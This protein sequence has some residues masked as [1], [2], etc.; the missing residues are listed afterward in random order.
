MV[1]NYSKGIRE[2]GG[3]YTH[4][5]IWAVI[6][7]TML[8]LNEKA[9]EYFKIINPIEHSKTKETSNKYKVEPYVVAADIYGNGDLAGRGGWTWYTGSSSW[10]YI[11]IIEYILGV[12]IKDNCLTI[13]PHIP[14]FWEEYEVKLN[15]KTSLYN[16]KISNLRRNGQKKIYINNNLLNE[17]M[18]RL[19]DD[20]KIYNIEVEI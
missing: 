5:A 14:D 3:Q 2:N 18:I 1:M 16:I 7:N 8:G 19:Y 15:Y 6:A 10:M 11:A 20:G 13:D 12:R 9:Y 17:D 4:A